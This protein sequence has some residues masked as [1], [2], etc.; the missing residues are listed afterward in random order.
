MVILSILTSFIFFSI[1]IFKEATP[2]LLARTKPDVR[3]VMIAISGGLALIIAISRPRPQFN[4]VAGVAIATAL[5]PPLCT[6]GFGLATG[7]L[8][9][10]GGALFLFTINCIYIALAAF[11][12]TKYLKFPMRKYINQVKRR[13]ISRLASLVALVI[14]GFSIYQF[15]LLYKVNHFTTL[16]EQFIDD[17]K[18][19]GV[20]LI[21]ESSES[22]DYRANE[23]KLYVFGRDYSERDEERW[24]EQLDDMGLTKTKL[25]LLRSQDN[26]GIREDIDKIKE[27]Y[28]NSHKMLSAKDETI[29]EKDI[30]ID[31]LEKDLRRYYSND[32]RFD[33]VLGEIKINY[34]DLSSISFA[35]EYRSDFEKLDTINIISV[36]WKGNVKKKSQTEQEERLKKWLEQRLKIKNLEVRRMP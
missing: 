8:S 3:D 6:A 24:R 11:A 34:E 25:T 35:R 9:Y 33:R 2:E 4:T 21:G 27:L 19:E 16:A 12:I 29:V 5:M 22:I 13:R 28:I 32:I 10:F 7:N 1:P 30:R 31:E 23:I 15:Y 17:L 20:N 36:K 14:L 18:A 26:T